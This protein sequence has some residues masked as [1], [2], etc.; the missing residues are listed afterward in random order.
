MMS[1]ERMEVFSEEVAPVFEVRSN[2][3]LVGRLTVSTGGVRWAP[4]GN[5]GEPYFVSWKDF[6]D[7]MR[8]AG[9]RK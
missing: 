7:L 4:S 6:D 5:K 3:D 2:K 8:K 1:T 9:A